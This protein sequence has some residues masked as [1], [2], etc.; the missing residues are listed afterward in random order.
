MKPNTDLDHLHARMLE[1]VIEYAVY[2]ILIFVLILVIVRK[3]GKDPYY[4]GI[5]SIVATLSKNWLELC[6]TFFPAILLYEWRISTDGLK[7][8]FDTPSGGTT[9]QDY[10]LPSVVIIIVTV[11]LISIV[12]IRNKQF[13]EKAGLVKYQRVATS[14]SMSVWPLLVLAELMFSI[15]FY[16]NWVIRVFGTLAIVIP[17]YIYTQRIKFTPG[18]WN[19]MILMLLKNDN[20]PN[21]DLEVL[22]CM[23]RTYECYRMQKEHQLYYSHVIE[24]A[25]KCADIDRIHSLTSTQ[26]K[27]FKSLLL[28]VILQ[29]KRLSLKRNNTEQS[30]IIYEQIQILENIDADL[31]F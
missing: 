12:Q 29:L 20:T 22:R 11:I 7:F 24:S 8:W 15:L 14:I 19:N 13:E 2:P 9:I 25:D 17:Y 18:Y 16:E 28:D 31:K 26:T 5:N 21:N 6:L 1:H 30:S 23:K 3:E 4:T 10:R 27:L